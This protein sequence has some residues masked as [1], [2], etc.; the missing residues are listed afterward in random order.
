MGSYATIATS[1][2]VS[3]TCC[4]LYS[5]GINLKGWFH[6]LQR[7]KPPTKRSNERQN[8][9]FPFYSF[10]VVGG[11]KAIVLHT[12]GASTP[13]AEKR[14]KT[15]WKQFTQS[16]SENIQH[17]AKNGLLVN[18]SKTYVLTIDKLKEIR[19]EQ[20]R[21]IKDLKLKLKNVQSMQT[22]STRTEYIVQT[23]VR[24]SINQGYRC[25]MLWLQNGMDEEYQGCVRNDLAS[26][27]IQN[28][29]SIFFRWEYGV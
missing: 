20:E 2:S 1:F 29:D 21:T 15:G 7:G 13:K 6:Q 16:Q 17:R 28:K 26:L 9:Y 3:L 18:E 14:L 5:L 4:R 19:E 22:I 27:D 12:P 10:A 23:I 25:A 24:D 11:T 8:K